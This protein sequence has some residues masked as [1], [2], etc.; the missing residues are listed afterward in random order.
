MEARP[1]PC[2]TGA[3]LFR[4]KLGRELLGWFSAL[5][6]GRDGLFEDGPVGDD[7]K[8]STEESSSSD[9]L[10]SDELVSETCVGE[11][12]EV[13]L[14]LSRVGCCCCCGCCFDFVGAELYER[15]G[16]IFS[17]YNQYEERVKV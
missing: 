5:L 4:A 1:V 12:S 13:C 7:A 17:D 16:A 8:S 11:R 2:N 10:T 9:V 3:V 15:G 14:C 6:S